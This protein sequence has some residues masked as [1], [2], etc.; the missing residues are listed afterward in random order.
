MD[1]TAP[2]CVNL[3]NGVVERV[4]LGQQGTDVTW[5]EPTCSD[6]SGVAS[7]LMRSHVPSS[8]FPVGMTTVTYT[9]TDGSGNIEMCSFTVVVIEG[10][11]KQFVN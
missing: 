6:A 2:S 9:C 8:F 7:V 4:E 1:T 11:Y 10:N 3:P 5:T